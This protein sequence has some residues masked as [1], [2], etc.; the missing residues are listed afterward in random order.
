[1]SMSIQAR[2]A[3][4]GRPTRA[5]PGEAVRSAES[6]WACPTCPPPPEW[7]CWYCCVTDVSGPPP[8]GASPVRDEV[9]ESVPLRE[10]GD[11]SRPCCRPRIKP[12]VAATPVDGVQFCPR[13]RVDDN[14]LAHVGPRRTDTDHEPTQPIRPPPPV[15][16]TPAALRPRPFRGHPTRRPRALALLRSLPDGAGDSQAIRRPDQG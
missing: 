5:G 3:G 16:S 2:S 12:A 4:R 14:A 11:D 1:M 7:F 13:H 8:A 10:F 6:R 9:T 15:H